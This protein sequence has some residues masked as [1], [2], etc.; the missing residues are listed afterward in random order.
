MQDYQ[1][2]T[3]I[4]MDLTEELRS[5]IEYINDTVPGS[6]ATISTIT[7]GALRKY[8]NN[9]NSRVFEGV[10][11]VDLPLEKMSEQDLNVLLNA[12]KT[13]DHQSDDFEMVKSRIDMQLLALAIEKKE[14]ENIE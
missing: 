7:R 14:G 4:P 11:S 6:G 3:R 2:R 12:F 10:M 8:V 1:L 13:I 9:F 5:V